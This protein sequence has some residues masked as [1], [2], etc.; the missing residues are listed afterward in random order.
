L[1][2]CG[3]RLSVS[4]MTDP[5]GFNDSDTQAFLSRYVTAIRQ[6]NVNK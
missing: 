4:L 5:F 2:V 3:G 1:C 6:W